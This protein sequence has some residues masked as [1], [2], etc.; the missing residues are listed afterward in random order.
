VLHVPLAPAVVALG[1]VQQ[2]GR[3]FLVAAREIGRDPHL[4]AGLAHQRGLDEI[5]AENAA[6]ERLPPGSS[7]RQQC[8]M[9]GCTRRMALCPQ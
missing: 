4:P 6:A 1:G 5:V 8:S 2:R 7:G 3:T 9:N